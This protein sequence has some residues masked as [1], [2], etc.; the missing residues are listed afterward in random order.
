MYGVG[1]YPNEKEQ[2]CA[3]SDQTVQPTGVYLNFSKRNNCSSSITSIPLE[4][5]EKIENVLLRKNITNILPKY[6][7]SDYENE[8][9]IQ[10][11]R[12]LKTLNAIINGVKYVEDN[13]QIIDKAS[14]VI[15][16]T[17]NLDELTIEK[18]IDTTT[19][20]VINPL[21]TQV[22]DYI[23]ETFGD[24]ITPESIEIFTND[25]DDTVDFV[26]EC[27]KFVY[28]GATD[29]YLFILANQENIDI[30]K[31]IITNI[32]NYQ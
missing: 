32:V 16:M 11:F 3:R 30:L 15:A 19:E 14:C 27:S 8:T 6:N 26:S 21:A 2:T 22:S 5:N 10:I 4:N 20:Y 31:E 9:I 25:V 1:V 12:G 18:I 13:Y 24:G 28:D 29:F 7:A 23:N 17:D